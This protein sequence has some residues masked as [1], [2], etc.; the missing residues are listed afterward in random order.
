M[1]IRFTARARA[2]L[3]AIFRY[4]AS[5]NPEDAA[6]LVEG[7]EHLIEKLSTYPDLGHPTRPPGRRVLTVPRAPY[8]VFYRVTEHE[9]RILMV[10]HTSRRSTRPHR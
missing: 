5:D 2:N 10:R 3:D 1:R 6:N 9:I 7:I 8:Q 4:I